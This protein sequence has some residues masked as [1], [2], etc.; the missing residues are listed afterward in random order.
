MVRD[1][2]Q[3]LFDALFSGRLYGR[4]AASLQEASRRDE[5]LRVVLRLRSPELAAVPWETMFDQETGEYICQREPVVR[6][7]EAAQPSSP[8]AAAGSLRVLGRHRAALRRGQLSSRP[9]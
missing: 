4:Y 8:L 5:P 7:V 9:G 3:T 6:Y 1:V 2:G